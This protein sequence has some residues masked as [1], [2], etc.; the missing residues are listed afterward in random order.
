M[1]KLWLSVCDFKTTS[2]GRGGGGGEL[3]LNLPFSLHCAHVFVTVKQSQSQPNPNLFLVKI[4]HFPPPP[5]LS[6]LSTAEQSALLDQICCWFS[7]NIPSSQSLDYTIKIYI[8]AF[9]SLS[10]RE[11]TNIQ[12]THSDLWEWAKKLKVRL[13]KAC[14]YG[15]TCIPNQECKQ[16]VCHSFVSIIP[17]ISV[18][19]FQVI[20]CVILSSP[21]PSH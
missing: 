10:P 3:S 17:L 19:S 12:H 14:T 20:Y 5:I 16:L 18:F 8:F 13:L 2:G 6:K 21:L 11:S 15:G 7:C 9:Q 4:S 1:F